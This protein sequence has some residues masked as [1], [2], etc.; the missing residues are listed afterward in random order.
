MAMN[1]LGSGGPRLQSL[2]GEADPDHRSTTPT[3]STGTRPERR[4]PGH[5]ARAGRTSTRPRG[6]PPNTPSN[7]ARLTGRPGNLRPDHRSV[8][9]AWARSP[10]LPH[11]LKSCP[12][13]SR[14]SNPDPESRLLYRMSYK[15][16][17][18]QPCNRYLI[19]F[20][21]ITSMHQYARTDKWASAL[22]PKY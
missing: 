1:C 11:R 15:L 6:T 2:R 12:T 4:N 8:T 13:G 10:E 7:A 18:H 3:G 22:L 14:L 9:G 20:I 21:S 17:S 19:L 16:D 5:R